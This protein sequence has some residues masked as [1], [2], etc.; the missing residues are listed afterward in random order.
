M[1]LTLNLLLFIVAF[2][3]YSD[4]TFSLSDYQIKK[5][6]EKEKKVYTCIKNLKKKRYDLNRG[7]LIEIPVVNKKRNF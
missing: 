5:I 2:L 7:S 1:K 3:T 6:C 4:K